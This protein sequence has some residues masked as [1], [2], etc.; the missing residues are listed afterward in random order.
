L[1]LTQQVCAAGGEGGVNGTAARLDD[2]REGSDSSAPRGYTAM[3]HRSWDRAEASPSSR[4]PAAA[5][6]PSARGSRPRR[7]RSPAGSRPVELRRDTEVTH[8]G[9]TGTRTEVTGQ[10]AGSMKLT[11]SSVP[12]GEIILNHM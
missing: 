2:L 4:W 3:T 12:N 5:C 11:R 1:T 10:S 9:H 7:T 8:R 6:R